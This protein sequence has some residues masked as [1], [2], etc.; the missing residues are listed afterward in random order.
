MENKI[1]CKSLKEEGE[2]CE[3]TDY[4]IVTENISSIYSDLKSYGI[5]IEKTT[6]YPGGGKTIDAK[7]IN[8]IFYSYTD[9][10]DFIEFAARNFTGPDEFRESVEKYIIQS[11]DRARQT[12]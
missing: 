5:K 4:Y 8:N 11:I 2:A 1:L 12:A 9:A 7:Q 6:V 10:E 3:F